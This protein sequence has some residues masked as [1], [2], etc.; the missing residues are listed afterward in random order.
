MKNLDPDTITNRMIFFI[1]LLM[2]GAFGFFYGVSYW[3][4]GLLGLIVGL[5]IGILCYF[6][7]LAIKSFFSK[8]FGTLA[9]ERAAHWSS[10]EQLEGDMN[11]ARHFKRNE[12]HTEALDTV[13]RIIRLDP[14]FSDAL[15][16]KAQILWE[17]FQNHHAAKSNLRK[18]F[19]IIKDENETIYRWA[20]SLSK[21]IDQEIEKH[22]NKN[23][24]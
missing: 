5:I 16:L 2:G 19:E 17:G 8:T 18:I 20:L 12:K 14:D 9:G 11:R 13:N 4:K 22:E 15:F 3:G 10:R 21:Q 23:L 6:M 7:A 1:S 24:S